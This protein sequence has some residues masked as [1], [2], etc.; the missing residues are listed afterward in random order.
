MIL[1]IRILVEKIL[2]IR[3]IL[4]KKFLKKFI[5]LIVT[6]KILMENFDDSDDSDE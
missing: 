2:M 4:L 6:M 3:M 1:T 5:L